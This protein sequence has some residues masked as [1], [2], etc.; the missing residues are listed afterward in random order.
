[1]AAPR[2]YAFVPF[3][4]SN[5]IPRVSA[6]SLLSS[7][8]LASPLHVSSQRR[9]RSSSHPSYPRL[10]DAGLE[11][12]DGRPIT[13]SI[14]RS[15]VYLPGNILPK[16][17]Y[18]RQAGPGQGKAPTP[19]DSSPPRRRCPRVGSSY[20]YAEATSSLGKG[21]E[22]RRSNL[23]TRRDDDFGSSHSL[24]L[25]LSLQRRLFRDSTRGS[26]STKLSSGSGRV[27]VGGIR[28]FSANQSTKR[29]SA[30]RCITKSW[31]GIE[32]SI[33]QNLLWDC[34]KNKIT[35]RLKRLSLSPSLSY[36]RATRTFFFH[37]TNTAYFCIFI[38]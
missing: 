26:F 20:I 24:S 1:M 34:V 36:T 18:L 3:A 31:S 4:F 33:L 12:Q 27:G 10:I 21:E 7:P 29:I 17:K 9:H 22:R 35:P 19:F 37:G 5:A 25:S 8:R 6:R 11:N 16:N 23:R 13:L 14:S 2:W 30:E 15:P 32:N 38:F 28:L